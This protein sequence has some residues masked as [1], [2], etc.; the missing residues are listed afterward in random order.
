MPVED[1]LLCQAYVHA[2]DQKTDI[3]WTSFRTKFNEVLPYH[4]VQVVDDRGNNAL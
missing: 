2:T 4:E 3:F 1:L